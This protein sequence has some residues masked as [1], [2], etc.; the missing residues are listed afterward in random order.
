MSKDKDKDTGTDRDLL[1]EGVGHQNDQI[2][3]AMREETRDDRGG[4]DREENGK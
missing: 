2:D 1:R 3:E 4:G